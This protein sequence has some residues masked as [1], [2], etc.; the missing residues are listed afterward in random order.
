V[1]LMWVEQ[2]R[3]C[4]S[5]RLLDLVVARTRAISGV[6]EGR[7]CTGGPA[8]PSSCGGDGDGVQGGAGRQLLNQ[9]E[10]RERERRDLV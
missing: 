2:G 6:Q 9:T 4:P 10:E 8:G 3:R 7:R 5:R 1:D